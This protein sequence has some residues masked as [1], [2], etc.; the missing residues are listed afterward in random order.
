M[1]KWVVVVAI[2]ATSGM[3][4]AQSTVSTSL[5]TTDSTIY[6]GRKWPA[7]SSLRGTR[8]VN[9]VEAA[10]PMPGGTW[11][12]TAGGRYFHG[13]DFL[14]DSDSNTYSSGQFVLAWQP[15]ELL[16]VTA[17]WS[18]V[19]NKNDQADPRTTQ[20]LGDPTIGVKL[21]HMLNNTLGLGFDTVLL[22][23][24]SAG[25]SGLK[26]DAFALDV[27]ALASYLPMSWLALS[28]NAGYRVDNTDKIF[29]E[30]AISRAQRFTAGVAT[31]NQILVGVGA[32]TYFVVGERAAIGPFAELTAGIA[33]GGGPFGENPIVATLGGRIQP[34][35]K[36][37]VDIGVGGDIRLAG[38]PR[39][40]APRLPG[41]PP[42]QLFARLSVHLGGGRGE[43][44]VSVTTKNTCSS[45]DECGRGQ[46]CT[47]HV[48]TITREVIREVTREVPLAAP[49][50]FIDGAV[51]DQTSGD[52]VGSAVVTIGGFETSPLAV[53][54]R[55]GKFHS[56]PIPVGEGLIKVT[57]SAPNYRPSE[58]T[59][60]R[61]T[62][63]QVTQ[64]TFKLQ[65][66][67]EAASG[68]IKG[69]IKDGRSGKP[70]KGEVFI[71]ALGKRLTSDKDGVFEAELKSGR[72]Q[73]L[74]SAPKYVTQKKEIEIRAGEVVILNLDMAGKK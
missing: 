59:I 30:R 68:Q 62:G 70:L 67:G 25:G 6:S 27:R 46:T 18:V 17:S 66:F 14:A 50:F 7:G 19:S 49:T 1:F 52:P 53:D 12:L 36:D 33:G 40:D 54:F 45:D 31:A 64:L 72:Y 4:Q 51:F 26:P 47:D 28:A 73:V 38:A 8:G 24:T 16:A 20:S 42:W 15:I 61:G 32:D 71:P 58:Q 60:A 13:G 55:N 23:P 34:A 65:A 63:D 9:R 22:I 69:S 39:E 74:I 43:Q 57:V 29:G 2:F 10:V 56:F 3:A 48:C 11:V 44:A 41:I 21:T 37:V 35:G 5:P